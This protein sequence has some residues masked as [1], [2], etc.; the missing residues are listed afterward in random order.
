MKLHTILQNHHG[1]W[2]CHRKFGK[3]DGIFVGMEFYF[4]TCQN[5]VCFCFKKIVQLPNGTVL[6]GFDHMLTLSVGIWDFLKL[7]CG[8]LYTRPCMINRIWGLKQL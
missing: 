7:Y 1:S 6:P 2:K 4:Y 5:M 8:Y 3:Y